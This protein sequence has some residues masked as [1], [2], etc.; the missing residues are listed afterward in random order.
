MNIK[1]RLRLAASLWL[2]M[3]K[4]SVW[5][6]HAIIFSMHDELDF[7]FIFV[8]IFVFILVIVALVYLTIFMWTSYNFSSSICGGCKGCSSSSSNGNINSSNSSRQDLNELGCL[9][10]CCGCQLSASEKIFTRHTQTAHRNN[11]K[12]LVG[13]ETGKVS[14]TIFVCYV[15]SFSWDVT[16]FIVCKLCV[17]VLF[18]QLY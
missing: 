5:Q 2:I 7:L 15:T 3:N 13:Q 12:A 17:A 11:N 16:R 6:T 1:S 14:S 9:L 8:F 18:A 4:R 10:V